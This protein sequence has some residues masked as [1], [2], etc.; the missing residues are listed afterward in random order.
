MQ[1]VLGRAFT[2]DLLTCM[3]PVGDMLL[4]LEPTVS[5]GQALPTSQRLHSSVYPEL[6][7]G[8]N[9]CSGSTFGFP[10]KGL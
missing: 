3:L 4:G 5:R 2:C 8:S 7:L 10:S 6:Y 9:P 1:I